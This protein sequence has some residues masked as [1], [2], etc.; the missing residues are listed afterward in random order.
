MLDALLDA[1]PRA[2]DDITV[3]LGD[4]IDR[5]PDSARAVARA[6]A[7]YDAAPDRTI[8]LWGNHEDMA[9]THFGF[10]A[11]SGFDYD[12]YDWFANGG[13]T[14]LQS[15]GHEPPGLFAA[16]C[17]EDLARLF[18]LLQTYWKA[19]AATFPDL[20]RYV[21]V[22]AGILAGQSAEESS[23]E[24]LLWV[25]EEFL[26]RVDTSGR[27]VVHGHTPFREVQIAADKIGID[28][29]AVFGGVLTALQL[30]ERRLFQADGDG[31]V[32]QLKLPPV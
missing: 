29:G 2:S 26:D 30:P 28:T 6:L 5:G 17:P 23:G 4:F 14:T 11:P 12:P 19:P 20:Q 3:F 25:R 1:L 21:W 8:F 13:L 15:Y 10:A 9:A 7:E 16:P 24:T 22:H 27:I 32:I 31:R 18:P